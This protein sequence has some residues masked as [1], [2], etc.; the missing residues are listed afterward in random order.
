[1]VKKVVEGKLYLFFEY[2]WWDALVTDKDKET[3]LKELNKGK[4]EDLY[5]DRG[6]HIWRIVLDTDELRK[7][8]VLL[9][10]ILKGLH[11]KKVRITVEVVE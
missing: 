1:M 4:D 3:L 10:D 11:G 6:D 8:G 9:R 5:E 2:E 7:H